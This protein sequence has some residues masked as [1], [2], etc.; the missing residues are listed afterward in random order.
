M[1]II[2]IFQN[3]QENRYIRKFIFLLLFD[4]SRPKNA[5]DRAKF[6]VKIENGRGATWQPC[7]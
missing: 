6:K 1:V 5:V 4:N 2:K 7:I 3:P